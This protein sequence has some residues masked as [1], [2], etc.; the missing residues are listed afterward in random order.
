MGKTIG[1][2]I[3][4]TDKSSKGNKQG[5]KQEPKGESKE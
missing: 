2:I 4:D 3:K 1:L 5:T